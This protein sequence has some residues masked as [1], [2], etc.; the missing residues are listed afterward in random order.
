M[1]VFLCLADAFRLR[2]DPERIEQ[3]LVKLRLDGSD[4]DP[5]PVSTFKCPVKVGTTIKQ[6]EDLPPHLKQVKVFHQDQIKINQ[7]LKI[8]KFLLLV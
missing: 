6:V 2:V 7:I 1:P 5:L 4:R 3:Q 8:L